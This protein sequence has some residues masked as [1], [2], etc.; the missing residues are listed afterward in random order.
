MGWWVMVIGLVIAL[1]LIGVYDES[2]LAFLTTS[3]QKLLS[4][5]GLRQRVE[6]MQQGV[7]GGITK[8]LLPAV[9]TYALLYLGLCLLLLR[10]LLP[11][12]AQWHLVLRLYA[13]AVVVY[14]ALVLLARFGGN[15]AWAYRL[16]RQILDFLVSPLPV[17]GLYVLLR[18]GL[19]T[20]QRG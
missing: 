20:R 6:A 15:V 12:R 16:S 11:L 7:N 17:A 2:V 4:A 3:W 18:A 1:L 8:R 19:G 13:G 14:V 10:V 5:V 9:A